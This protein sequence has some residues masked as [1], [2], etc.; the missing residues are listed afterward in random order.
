MFSSWDSLDTKGLDRFSWSIFHFNCDTLIGIENL[1]FHSQND[2]SITKWLLFVCTWNW[3]VQNSLM[4]NSRRQKFNQTKKNETTC[5]K[6]WRQ[7]TW[8]YPFAA[9]FYLEQKFLLLVLWFVGQVELNHATKKWNEIKFSSSSF[10][11]QSFDYYF[12]FGNAK[13]LLFLLC[14]ACVKCHL[15]R[16]KT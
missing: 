4:N 3:I 15:F 14:F 10:S 1:N 8:L 16:C 13:K 9:T 6:I 5:E 11:I 2:K 7:L 12:A